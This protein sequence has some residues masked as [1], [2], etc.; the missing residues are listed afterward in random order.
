MCLVCFAKVITLTFL[1]YKVL[2]NMILSVYLKFYTGSR[3][4][5]MI[6]LCVILYG[7]CVSETVS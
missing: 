2:H 6:A 7:D 1:N 3:C 5:I 4:P